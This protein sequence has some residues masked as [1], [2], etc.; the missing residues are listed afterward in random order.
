MKNAVQLVARK[1]RSKVR[2]PMRYGL[3]PPPRGPERRAVISLL[4][5]M[6][7]GGG[8]LSGSALSTALK[9]TNRDQ[10]S[11]MRGAWWNVALPC[12]PLWMQLAPPT[13]LRNRR[14]CRLPRRGSHSGGHFTDVNEYFLPDYIR[15]STG[16]IDPTEASCGSG[17]Q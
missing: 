10:Q 16:L 13:P 3:M 9:W 1:A 11:L 14:Q 7:A 2:H 12:C 8:H 17:K 15:T 6:P 4:I 5:S